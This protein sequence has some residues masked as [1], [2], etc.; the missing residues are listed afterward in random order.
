MTNKRYLLAALVGCLAACAQMDTPVKTA[1]AKIGSEV[2]WRDYEK[3]RAIESP[4]DARECR[5]SGENACIIEINVA[6]ACD[7][8]RKPSPEYLHVHANQNIVW[9]IVG[10]Q[11]D[12]DGAGIRWLNPPV[13]LMQV[14]NG[15]QVRHWKVGPNPAPGMYNYHVELTNGKDKCTIDPALWV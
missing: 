3:L 5:A 7:P 6:V 11:W 2:T 1:S 10:S 13:P 14:A 15:P 8:Q 12:F 9:H 4:V